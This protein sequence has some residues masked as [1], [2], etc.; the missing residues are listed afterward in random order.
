[1]KNIIQYSII[2][3]LINKDNKYYQKKMLDLINELKELETKYKIIL[4]IY[5]L[6]DEPNRLTGEIIK[7]KKRLK[8]E[9]YIKMFKNILKEKKVKLNV[10]FRLFRSIREYET[11]NDMLSWFKNIGNKLADSFVIIGNYKNKNLR[12]DSVLKTLCLNFPEKKYGCIL[13][14]HRDNELKRCK[15]RIELGCS[16]FISQI[17]VD[18]KFK[19]THNQIFKEINVPIY[20]TITHV[21]SKNF[22]KFLQTLGVK[23]YFD[24]EKKIVDD[25]EK[26][27]EHLKKIYTQVKKIKHFINFE[28]MS[29]KNSIRLFYIKLFLQI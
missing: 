15:K 24:F 9:I 23:S 1:M 3:P 22:W 8:P 13:I 14:P 5:D 7:Q 25:K 10:E 4:S 27:N 26:M 21:T 11:I 16:F 29:H 12:T 6:I 28:I 17:I 2:P 19:E 20:F 18:D